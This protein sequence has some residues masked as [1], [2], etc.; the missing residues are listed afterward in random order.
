M[1]GLSEESLVG[2]GSVVKLL[3]GKRSVVK[4]EGEGD[5]VGSSLRLLSVGVSEVTIVVE[6]GGLLSVGSSSSETIKNDDI[7]FTY[8]QAT[9][10]M[11]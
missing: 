9:F 1:S 6:L 10:K 8:T 4:V 7:L 11:G 5:G 3:V 2:T